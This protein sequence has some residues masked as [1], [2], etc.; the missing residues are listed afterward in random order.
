MTLEERAER[1]VAAA[2]SFTLEGSH[3]EHFLDVQLAG[4]KE[5][6][7]RE[8]IINYYAATSSPKKRTKLEAMLDGI[9]EE[10][11]A[12]PEDADRIMS[13][14]EWTAEDKRRH[15]GLYR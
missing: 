11:F 8:A 12:A 4:L 9:D 14:D 13:L 15:P 3:D 5:Y 7:K 10:Y 6:W 1:K 2:Y